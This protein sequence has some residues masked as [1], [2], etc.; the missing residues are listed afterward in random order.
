MSFWLNTFSQKV[1][2]WWQLSDGKFHGFILAH[3]LFDTYIRDLDKD[4]K[5]TLIK[6][7]SDES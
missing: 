1:F 4:M 6:F 5:G 2:I 7:V 3:I